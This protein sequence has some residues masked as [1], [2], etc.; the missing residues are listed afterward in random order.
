[1]MAR[2]TL[3]KAKRESILREFNHRCAIC[4][5]DRPHIHHID[6]DATNNELENLLP[7]CPNCHLLDQ[8]NPTSPVDPRK[9]YL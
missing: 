8:H 9:L 6:E 5:S 1:M 7:L 4:G 3:P 2:Q